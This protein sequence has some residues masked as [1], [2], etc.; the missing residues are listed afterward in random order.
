MKRLSDHLLRRSRTL[1][2]ACGLLALTALPAHAQTCA[3]PPAG[4]VSWWPLDETSG[5]AVADV[6]GKNPGTATGPIGPSSNPKSA[7]GFV[8][9]GLNFFGG[10]RVMVKADPS[11][12][13]GTDKSFTIDAW[14]KGH[15]SPIVSNYASSTKPVAYYSVFVA[16]DN[17]LAL[18]MGNGTPVAQTW[19][20]PTIPRDVWTF[21]AVVVDRTK[22]TVTFYT[23]A[24]KG[25]LATSGPLS[26][27]NPS[28]ANAGTKLPLNIGGCPGNAVNCT[29]IIDEL[30]IF[31]RALERD[32]LQSIVDA[33]SA[34]KCKPSGPAKGMTWRWGAVN[35]TNGTVTVGCGNGDPVHPC[36][37]YA[38]DQ[39]CTDSL[40]LLCFKPSSFPSPKSVV[41]TDTNNRW[42]GGIVATTVPVVPAAAPIN[43]SLASANARCALEFLSPDWRVAEFHDG[44]KG[45]GGWNFQ[46]YGN[47]GKPTSRFWVHIKDQPKG[48]CFT[49]P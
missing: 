6:V 46:A 36:N 16:T 30:E 27:P 29:S 20:G 10:S 35:A 37:P 2:A 22:N 31:N 43:G 13:F 45:T 38:G 33:D 25:K 34:G 7:T 14:V 26:T 32:E 4:L 28:S 42:S 39:L 48:T 41:D 44:G 8:G 3:P 21:V 12:D 9:K 40:P 19:Y 1:A 49:K 18:E 11:L 23:A 15:T 17:K 5:T 24:P 47:V